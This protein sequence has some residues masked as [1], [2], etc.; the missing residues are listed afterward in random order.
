MFH[1]VRRQ[2]MKRK[3][4]SPA[5]KQQDS[6]DVWLDASALKR[7]KM[8]NV[9]SKS[10]LSILDKH[11]RPAAVNGSHPCTKQTT[12]STFFTAPKAGERNAGPNKRLSTSAS[13]SAVNLKD[14]ELL[15]GERTTASTSVLQPSALQ[16]RKRQP[17]KSTNGWSPFP[18]NSFPAQGQ[19][20]NSTLRVATGEAFLTTDLIQHLEEKGG[21]DQQRVP[22]SPLKEKNNGWQREKSP[23]LFSQS[24]QSFKI[25]S[26]QRTNAGKRR[27]PPCT[28]TT[29]VNSCDS[30]NM[31]PELEEN[32]PE[33]A[34]LRHFNRTASG[35]CTK[36]KNATSSGEKGSE[37]S[38]PAPTQPL[39]TQ[40]SEGHK[41][42]LHRFWDERGK[43]SSQK[44]PWWGK[45]SPTRSSFYKGCFEDCCSGE[46]SPSR[47]LGASFPLLTDCSEKSCYD[48]LFS[49]D[50]EGNKVI[51]H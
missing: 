20:H 45:S 26:S 7:R 38:S 28:D 2:K 32:T 3:G 25:I 14:H 11:S 35:F 49:E 44:E 50:S 19:S 10:A 15:R 29:F 23:T 9:V 1:V 46:R 48:L 22:M 43:P 27:R 36:H 16:D 37:N 40:D 18:C 31:E 24:S 12:I 30:E 5:G 34:F 39:F 33:A 41:V 21:L 17:A 4:R 47:A 6:C 8:M 42:I 51:K 13:N